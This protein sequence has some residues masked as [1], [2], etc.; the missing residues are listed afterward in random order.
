MNDNIIIIHC[1]RLWH[2]SSV[3]KKL[4]THS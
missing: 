1:R 2:C 4:Q 3:S